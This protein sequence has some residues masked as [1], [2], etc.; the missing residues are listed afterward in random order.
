MISNAQQ[1]YVLSLHQKKYRKLNRTFIVEGRKNVLEL[2][3]SDFTIQQLFCTSEFGEQLKTTG[4]DFPFTV[5]N[6]KELNKISTLNTSDQVLAVVYQNEDTIF[7]MEPDELVLLLDDV[8]DPGNL[9]TIIRVADWYGIKQIIC[10]ENTV[11]FYNP[12][13]IM[14]TMG[15]FTRVKFQTAELADF[16]QKNAGN[17]VYGAYLQGESVYDINKFIP[18]FLILGS[19]SHGISDKL[20]KFITKKIT[21][22]RV[23]GA[24]SLN[25]AVSTA[26]LLDNLIK[27]K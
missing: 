2:L 3:S 24:E 7:S 16:L 20:E 9:G 5:I 19:E 1:K 14:S 4:G 21:I 13:V 17:E 26:V 15:S 12:K 6:E 27:L 10:S 23:G 22:P 25:V 8:S 11:D 18:G